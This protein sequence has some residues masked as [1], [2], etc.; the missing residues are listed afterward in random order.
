MRSTTGTSLLFAAFARSGVF[1]VT[2]APARGAPENFARAPLSCRAGS[3]ILDRRT[4]KSERGPEAGPIFPDRAAHRGPRRY[5]ANLSPV[6]SRPPPPA[7]EL[8]SMSRA[9]QPVSPTGRRLVSHWAMM[10]VALGLTMLGL[11]L[12]TL[13]GSGADPWLVGCLVAGLITAGWSVAQRL[14]TGFVDLE[15]RFDSACLVA[16]AALVAGIAWIAVAQKNQALA[17]VQGKW[18]SN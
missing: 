17:A 13:E 9:A 10:L 6:S 16:G 3:V 2:A 11:Y 8:P 4:G 7:Q 14:R 5:V 1:P 15:A 18:D 12:A